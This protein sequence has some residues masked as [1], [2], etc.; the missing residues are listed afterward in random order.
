LGSV[1]QLTNSTSLTLNQSYEPYG[2]TLSSQGSGESSYGFAGEWTE[3]SGLVYLR[4]RYYAPKTGR[5]I[6]KDVWPGDAMR[7]VSYNA[8]LYGYG[9]PCNYL[10]PSGRIP[11]PTDIL[12]GDIVYSCN[13]G[14]IDFSHANPLFGMKIYDLL[15]QYDYLM[16][17]YL[18]NY[19]LF[20]RDVF[21]INPHVEVTLAK[22]DITAVIRSSAMNDDFQK[23]GVAYS[24]YKMLMEKVENAQG[25]AGL[26]I[27]YYSFEDLASDEIGF[28]LAKKY[29]ANGDARNNEEAWNH[30][31]DICGFDTNRG[32]ARRNTLSVWLELG[33]LSWIFDT[34]RVTEWDSPNLFCLDGMCNDGNHQ[35]PDEFQD[36]VDSNLY[37]G[38][39]NSW[40]IYTKDDGDLMSSTN[41]EFYYLIETLR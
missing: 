9:N 34:P 11:F 1:R 38:L 16:R 6:N 2:N 32:T 3:E 35:W 21:A 36:L 10:D 31:A 4:A 14:F 12:Q 20:R 29:G 25:D 19:S 39:H 7:P 40:W 15:D 17:D 18:G 5:F 23:D 30:L 22:A 41:P 26:W 37:F 8:W 13:C 24:I 33:G 27:T 28:Y